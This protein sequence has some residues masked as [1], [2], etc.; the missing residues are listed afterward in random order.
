M[1]K[2]GRLRYLVKE[3]VQA[4]GGITIPP[5]EE[6]KRISAVE[7]KP[8]ESIAE[9]ENDNEA[10]AMEVPLVVPV[11]NDD[12]EKDVCRICRSESNAPENPLISACKCSGSIKYI[13][14]DCMRAWYQSKMLSRSTPAAKTYTVKGLECELCKT[15]LSFSLVHSG[16]VLDLVKIE[17]PAAGP[18]LTLESLQ[19]PGVGKIVHVI[20]L[21]PGG[22]A[23]IV[24][25]KSE[26]LSIG[27]RT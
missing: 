11:P 3:I 15:K 6:A 5:Q 2:F 22:L 9:T 23:R 24:S 19:D 25:P 27:K 14:A 17:K 16:G 7:E 26:D 4:N 18:Y 8:K 21:V 20:S 1:V 12:I 13:H 10:G